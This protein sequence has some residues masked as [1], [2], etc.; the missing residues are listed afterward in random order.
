MRRAVSL[1]AAA[2]LVVFLLM[3]CGKSEKTVY[4]SREGKVT[5]KQDRL[6]GK[7]QTVN[8]ETKEG[9]ATVTTGERKT[10]TEA[11]LGV[12]VYPGAVVEVTGTYQSGKAGGDE[13]VEQHILYTTDSFDKVVSFYKAKLKNIK[14]EQ[15]MSSGDTKLAIFAVG[16]ENNQTMVQI[17]WSASEKRTMI[18]VMKQKKM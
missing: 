8:V 9:K 6:G 11:E 1:A 3:G 18:H 10:I 15:N 14:S 5:V 17:N 16:E 4:S 12:P 7:E 13:S 2:G